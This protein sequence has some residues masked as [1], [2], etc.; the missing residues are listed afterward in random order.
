MRF[1]LPLLVLLSLGCTGPQ[2]ASQH[3]AA[4]SRHEACPSSQPPQEFDRAPLVQCH[5]EHIRWGEV[6]DA[7]S[8]A[9]TAVRLPGP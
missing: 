5:P 7:L 6:G 1:M 8:G 2:A 3:Q 4:G 9:A